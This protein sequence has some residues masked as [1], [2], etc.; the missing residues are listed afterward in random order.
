V[1]GNVTV[2]K[3]EASSERKFL[4]CRGLRKLDLKSEKQWLR[5]TGLKTGQKTCLDCKEFVQA[6]LDHGYPRHSHSYLTEHEAVNHRVDFVRRKS[7]N[8]FKI[9]KGFEG[10]ML[11]DRLCQLGSNAR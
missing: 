7:R 5:Q 11:D 1:F 8:I 9:I 3:M 4:H 2:P 6:W 10:S